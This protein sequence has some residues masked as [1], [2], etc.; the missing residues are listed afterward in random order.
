MGPGV[1]RLCLASFS[2]LFFSFLAGSPNQSVKFSL[3]TSIIV[4]YEVVVLCTSCDE[5]ICLCFTL[6]LI[7][8]SRMRVTAAAYLVHCLSCELHCQLVFLAFLFVC[9]LVGDLEVGT[10]YVSTC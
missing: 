7:I 4:I 10:G 9:L 6:G 2:F 1:A 8:R 3:C 5:T